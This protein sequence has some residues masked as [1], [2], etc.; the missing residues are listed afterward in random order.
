MITPLALD[1]VLKQLN[2]PP[3]IKELIV[4]AHWYEDGWDEWWT[5][6][7]ANPWKEIQPKLQRSEERR[8]L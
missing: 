5:E 3:D 1:T 7:Y 4:P 6:E 8:I 2:N